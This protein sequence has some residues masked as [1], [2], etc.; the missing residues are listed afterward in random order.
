MK[1]LYLAFKRAM[2]TV[3]VPV[4]L[5]MCAAVAFF[6]PLMS[7]EERL[8]MAAV[9][10]ADDSEMA[11]SAVS[12]LL[13]N[14][15]AECDSEESLRE[16]LARGEYNCGVIIYE[17]FEERI[18]QGD[19]EGLV[20]YLTT[21]SSYAP[22]IYQ[23]HVMTAI[24]KEYA[25]YITASLIDD[26]HFT[27]VEVIERYNEMMDEGG[28][29]TFEVTREDSAAVGGDDR[30]F[31]YTVGLSAMLI[32]ALVM[33]GVISSVTTDLETMR[34]RIGAGRAVVYTVIPSLAVRAV[35][36]VAAFS[37]GILFSSVY[38]G[39]KDLLG[40]IGAVAI[41][42]LLVTAFGVLIASVC[43]NPKIIEIITFFILVGGLVLC[44]IYY[45]ISAMIPWVGTFRNIL[46]VYWLWLCSEHLILML[47]ITVILLPASV[48]LLYITAKKRK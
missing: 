16:M 28:R 5:L 26:S 9:Y 1:Y 2:R 11:R 20:L 23:N 32:F 24:Y 25:P 40:V 15:F 33:Y 39:N 14:N 3:Y 43:R 37:A 34:K 47:S 30:A 12:Y 41:Y 19:T 36:V 7:E 29:F 4:L 42:T 31:A 13:D 21:P 22:S 35:S 6:A 17:G 45:D 8:P 48:A 44:P 27:D 18:I 10:S 38:S 46:P